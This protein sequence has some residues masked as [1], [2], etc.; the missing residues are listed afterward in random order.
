MA[1]DIFLTRKTFTPSAQRAGR[2]IIMWQWNEQTLRHSYLSLGNRTP[3]TADKARWVLDCKS[4]GGAV[5]SPVKKVASAVLQRQTVPSSV[6]FKYPLSLWC[7]TMLNL[8]D[9]VFTMKLVMHT[10]HIQEID[11]SRRRAYV[12]FPCDNTVKIQKKCNQSPQNHLNTAWKI[13]MAQ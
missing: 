10:F 5:R 4:S 12:N 1:I 8:A 2:N 9:D 13:M 7:W 11:Y 3:E 6:R